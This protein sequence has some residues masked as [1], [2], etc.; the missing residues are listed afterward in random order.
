MVL[1]L[2]CTGLYAVRELGRAG[3]PVLGV[4]DAFAAGSWSR[5]ASRGILTEPDRGR[6]VDRLRAFARTEDAPPVL[7]PVTDR[8]IEWLAEHHEALTGEFAFA[9]SFRDGVAAALMDKDRFYETCRR[10]GVTHPATWTIDSA[11]AGSA[12]RRSVRF[13]VILKP[14]LVHRARPFLGRRKVVVVKDAATYE[15]T[16]AGLPYDRTPWLIQ[17]IVAG[18]DSS[19]HVFAG[20]FDTAGEPIRTFTAR[21]LRQFPPAFGSA[22]LAQS[23]RNDEVAELSI[24]L[25][26]ALGFTGLCGTEF[27]RDSRDGRLVAIEVNPRPTLWCQLAHASGVRLV[28]A[29][30]CDLAGLDPGPPTPQRDGIRW[31]Y[32]LR[33]LYSAWFY[34]SVRDPIRPA[35]ATGGRVA[36]RTWA[37]WSA[38]DPLP[39]LA[40]PLAVARQLVR[41]TPSAAAES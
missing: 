33:D 12:L 32:L 40:E 13:P 19:I 9:R 25:L 38:R 29:A 24:R 20:Y 11:E 4:T 14:T 8:Y 37:V 35:P 15:A 5:Y 22:S 18:P 6:L 41:G 3:L 17:E 23:E 39:A 27:K 28:E 34:R 1:G 10:L 2:S 36:G 16:L 31:Q 7:I 26:T 30:V 21:K